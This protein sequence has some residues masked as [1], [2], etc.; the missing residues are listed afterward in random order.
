MKMDVAHQGVAHEVAFRSTNAFPRR[1]HPVDA[2]DRGRGLFDER[3][4][5]VAALCVVGP[6]ARLG[7]DRLRSVGEQARELARSISTRLGAG[8]APVLD[9]AVR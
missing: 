5:V 8:V 4:V 9:D 3:G 2:A 1:P 7:R 6:S